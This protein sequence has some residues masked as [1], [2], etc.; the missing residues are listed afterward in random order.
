MKKVSIV[1]PCYN[2]A[3]YLARCMEHIIRQTIGLENIEIILVDDASTDNGATLQMIMEYE[4]KY[5]ETVIAVPLEQNMRQGGARNIGISYAGGEYLMFCDADDWLSLDAME[6]L[7]RTAQEYQADVVEY[8]MKEVTVYDEGIEPVEEEYS[9]YLGDMGDEAYRKKMLMV[10]AD[11]FSLG[12][13]RKFYRLSLILDNRIRFAEHLRLEEPSFTLPVRLYEKTHICIDKV[14]YYYFQTPNS[15]MRG[16]TH[17][18][19]DRKFDNA[20]VW[21]SLIDDLEGRGF[22]QKYYPELECMFYDWGFGLSI[23]MLLQKGYT[24]TRDEMQFFKEV[25]LRLFPN[26]KRNPYIRTRNNDW[27]MILHTVLETELTQENVQEFNRIMQYYLY[28]YAEESEKKN[29]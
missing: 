11:D 9:V 15:T 2:T 10:S 8:L 5:P 7:Y 16:G 1:V 20:K 23:R 27:D 13:M 26:I 12:C 19:D 28:R 24:L 18:W 3:A 22:L 21:I 25:M 6:I 17:S 14:L 29:V 4:Q